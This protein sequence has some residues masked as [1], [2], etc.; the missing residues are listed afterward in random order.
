MLD[1][2]GIIKALDVA[3]GA[4]SYTGLF[5][6]LRPLIMKTLH[7]MGLLGI[8]ALVDFAERNIKMGKSRKAL[9]GAEK[10][11]SHSPML[12]KFLEAKEVTPERFTEWDIMSNVTSNVGAGSDTTAISLSAVFHFIYSNPEALQKL[13]EELEAAGLGDI[14]RFSDTQRLPYF[15]AV[16]KESLRL[17]PGT[18]FPMFREVPEGGAVISG[19]FF[20]PKVSRVPWLF[21]SGSMICFEWN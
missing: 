7:I 3:I 4:A 15:Q 10:I 17:H 19:Q 12:N 21:I 20:P 9:S 11:G 16:V 6:P 18:G 2:N 8:D 5:I 1:V 13:R 14:P